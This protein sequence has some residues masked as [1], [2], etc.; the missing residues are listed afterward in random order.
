MIDLSSLLM[1]IPMKKGLDID[2]F[3]REINH[4]QSLKIHSS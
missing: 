2:V 1:S 3:I 4:F